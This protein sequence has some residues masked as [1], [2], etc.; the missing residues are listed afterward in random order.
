VGSDFFVPVVAT[1]E[2]LG[3]PDELYKRM[4]GQRRRRERVQLAVEVRMHEITGNR[5]APLLLRCTA[6]LHGHQ[7][8]SFLCQVFGQ[9]HDDLIYWG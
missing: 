7:K 4:E 8:G 5:G 6:I 3:L 1:G 9:P 2:G